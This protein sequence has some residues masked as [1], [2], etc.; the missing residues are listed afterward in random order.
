M[1]DETAELRIINIVSSSFALV[2]TGTYVRLEN[3]ISD[4]IQGDS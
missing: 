3:V 2:L 1:F 4:N